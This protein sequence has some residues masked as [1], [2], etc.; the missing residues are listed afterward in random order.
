MKGHPAHGAA[1]TARGARPDRCVQWVNGFQSCMLD[2]WTTVP[3]VSGWRSHTTNSCIRSCEQAFMSLR[4]RVESNTDT[5]REALRAQYAVLR[6][7]T[8]SMRLAMMDDL[9]HLVQMMTREGLRR[10]HPSASP[11]ELDQLFSELVLGRELAARVLENRQARA[12]AMAP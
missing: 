3:S 9:T 11:A 2:F 5:S 6:R 10:R 8:P 1:Q 7:M 4:I 12:N